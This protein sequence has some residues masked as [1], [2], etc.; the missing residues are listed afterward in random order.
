MKIPLFLKENSRNITLAAISF[1]IIVAILIGVYNFGF[2][3]GSAQSQKIYLDGL[4]GTQ[5][6]ADQEANFSSFWD[7]WQLIKEK[8]VSK[9]KTDD[10]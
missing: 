1:I 9:E 2:D 8:Y 10:N 7:A 5:N 4:T 6:N 3:R